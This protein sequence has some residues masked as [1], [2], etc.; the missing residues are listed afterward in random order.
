MTSDRVVY[1]HHLTR[2]RVRPTRDTPRKPGCARRRRS[3]TV[4]VVAELVIRPVDPHDEADMDGFQDVY[5]AAERSEDPEVGLYSR[6]DGVAMLTSPDPSSLFEAF[7][8]LQG[9]RMV[10]ESI[11]MGSNRDNLH[12]ARLLLWVHPQHQRQ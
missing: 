9:G 12:M 2:T 7:G 10:G 6:E 3:V 1:V 5:A 8:A 4:T 11:L